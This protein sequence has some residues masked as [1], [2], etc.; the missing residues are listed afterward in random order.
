M[1]QGDVDAE[2]VAAEEGVLDVHVPP[3][4]VLTPGSYFA[5]VCIYFCFCIFLVT[6]PGN[7][8]GITPHLTLRTHKIFFLHLYRGIY[9][10][11]NYLKGSGLG[12]GSKIL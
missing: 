11:D 12:F 3:T 9:G 2:G 1:V 6:I 8:F 4:K 5:Q 10:S 7:L